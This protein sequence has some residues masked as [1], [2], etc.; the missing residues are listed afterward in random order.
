MKSVGSLLLAFAL[1]QAAAADENWG[2]SSGL[3]H[4]RFLQSSDALL[5]EKHG[6]DDLWISARAHGTD[7]GTKGLDQHGAISVA[8]SHIGRKQTAHTAKAVVG[9][10][11]KASAFAS[12]GGGK[13]K[14][15]KVKTVTTAT[16]QAATSKQ[17]KAQLAQAMR[18]Q[19]GLRRRLKEVGTEARQHLSQLLKQLKLAKTGAQKS[20]TKLRTQIDKERARL[21]KE[22]SS[23]SQL[24]S[25][26][27][28]AQFSALSESHAADAATIQVVAASRT[29]AQQ[30]ETKLRKQ[31]DKEESAESGLKSQLF[32]AQFSALSARHTADAATNQIAEQRR[33]DRDAD[34]K[35][36]E[37][38]KA[39][40]QQ[41]QEETERAQEANKLQEQLHQLQQTVAK[42]QRQST[43]QLPA[44]TEVAA[45][46]VVP[47]SSQKVS[48]KPST[49]EMMADFFAKPK[50]R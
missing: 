26:L 10:T 8:V 20:E 48:P 43:D 1:H 47:V 7:L 9:K 12:A 6:T 18:V 40:R 17:L 37:E 15:D 21:A 44:S 2:R 36:R 34:Q 50:F 29:E 5:E 35:L 46:P 38:L 27:F 49:L 42:G 24:R 32:A 11:V 23:E 30:S 19:F 3:S 25:Q 14:V 31:L 41:L 39:V 16:A 33:A 22:E 13:L 28:A 45:A 4:T